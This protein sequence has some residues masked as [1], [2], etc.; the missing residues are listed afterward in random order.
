MPTCRLWRVD[1]TL[2]TTLEGHTGGVWS[3][4]FSPDGSQIVTASLDGKIRLWRADGTLITILKGHRGAVFSAA[5]NSDGSQ[6]VSA[7]L[8]GT[9]RLWHIDIDILLDEGKRQLF[10]ML[11][12]EECQ[13]Y[14]PVDCPS[15]ATEVPIPSS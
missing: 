11:T 9:A 3:A 5:F 12:L 10:P 8:D 7:S 6:I 1:G 13:Q 4:A 15:N 2:I 14:F